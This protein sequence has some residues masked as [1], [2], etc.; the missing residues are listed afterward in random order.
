MN[1]YISLILLIC[2][3]SYANEA[4]V[5]DYDEFSAQGLTNGKEVFVLTG[6]TV[7]H[8]DKVYL[9]SISF[10]VGEIDFKIP[11]RI[12]ESLD[13]PYFALLRIV[14]DSG[15]YGNFYSISL[16]FGDAEQCSPVDED[17]FSYKELFIC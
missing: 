17:S 1:K 8:E 6:K 4:F 10:R 7:R 2:S 11:E 12:M 13:S 15:I 16:P 14:N 3:H 9:E 5:L